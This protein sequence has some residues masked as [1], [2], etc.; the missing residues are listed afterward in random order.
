L[1]HP[2]HMVESDRAAWGALFG[3]Y[4]IAQPFAQL[5][6]DTYVLS[7]EETASDTLKRFEGAK[8]E[9]KRLRGMT[10]RG[11]RLGA[12]QDSGCVFWVQRRVTLDDGQQ[13]WALLQFGE[14]LFSGAADYEDEVQV[15]ENV[16]LAD[17][18]W[19]WSN[20][21]GRHTFGRLD[22]VNASELLR[23]LSQLVDASAV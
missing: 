8:V 6:R 5:G 13:T 14:G 21:N 17:S 11:W 18:D 1:V 20:N 10:S 15:L 9:A 16:T 23:D 22:A 7:A 3:D 19:G 2:L 4:E 12:P